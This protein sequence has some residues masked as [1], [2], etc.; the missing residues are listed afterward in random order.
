MKYLIF[1]SLFLFFCCFSFA[2]KADKVV[3]YTL[4]DTVLARQLIRGALDCV[5]RARYK[6]VAPKTDSAYAIFSSLFGSD[7]NEAA[8]AIHIKGYGV[9]NLGK[10]NEAIDLYNQSLKIRIFSSHRREFVERSRCS[11]LAQLS[12]RKFFVS[13]HH[14]SQ[15]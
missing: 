4:G 13:A 12:L 1:V 10:T 2:Q 3:A 9:L 11:L 8:D 5:A 14:K 6:D 15:V 7:S